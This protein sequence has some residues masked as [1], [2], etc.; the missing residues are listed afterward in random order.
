MFKEFFEVRDNEVDAQGVVNNSH[1]MN[2]FAHT[3]H[4]FLDANGVNF[5]EMSKNNQMLFL[6]RSEIDYKLPLTSN[7]EFYVTCTMSIEGVRL[8]FNQEIRT[9]NN[10]LIAVSKNIGVCMNKNNNKNRPYIPDNIKAIA[11]QSQ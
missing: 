8:I 10:D 2:Y 1:Y 6:I 3:R 9:N 5:F 4:K 7:T 11:D